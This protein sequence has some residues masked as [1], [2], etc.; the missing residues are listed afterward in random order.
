MKLAGYIRVSTEK[1]RDGFGPDEQRAAIRKWCRANGHRVVEWHED[2]VS[3]SWD[4][5]DAGRQG[6][7]DAEQA[8]KAGRVNG[9]VIAR[10]DRLARD[11][12]PQEMLLRDVVK[13]GGRTYSAREGE[14]D[15]MHDDPQDPSRKL[16]RTIFGAVAAYDRDMTV[17]RLR[18][19]RQ[20]KADKGGHANGRYPYGFTS[21]GKDAAQQ[22]ALRLMRRWHAE[23]KSTREIAHLLRDGNHPTARGGGWSPPVVA[24][25]LARESKAAS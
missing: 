5:F 10:L 14:N 21:K 20:A 1:Q 2:A 4:A 16:V 15:V 18:A 23:G 17:L 25:I 9:I 3:G 22:R 24:R 11:I 12:V 19:A 8:I 7:A 6:W 13:A